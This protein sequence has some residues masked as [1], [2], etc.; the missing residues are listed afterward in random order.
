MIDAFVKAIEQ[1]MG[2]LNPYLLIGLLVM[3][4]FVLFTFFYGT[5]HWK[6]LTD[7]DKAIFIVSLGFIWTLALFP[8]SI[9][10]SMIL[11]TLINPTLP[12]FESS[13]NP[14]SIFA[15][16]ILV[17]IGL[18]WEQY[19]TLKVGIYTIRNRPKFVEI[20]LYLLSL[21]IVPILVFVMSMHFLDYKM[22]STA[23]ITTSMY[24]L[25]V[26]SVATFIFLQMSISNPLNKIRKIVSNK[27]GI[28]LI[29]LLLILV[30]S[31][32]ITALVL[33]PEFTKTHEE[34]KK[35]YFNRTTQYPIVGSG[36]TFKNYFVE[37]FAVKFRYLKWAPIVSNNIKN[38]ESCNTLPYD[39]SGC[40]NRGDHVVIKGT[41]SNIT[42]TIGG[43]SN[44][45]RGDGF[46][47]DINST[48]NQTKLFVKNPFNSTLSF[49]AKGY[50][51]DSLIF[52]NSHVGCKL[53]KILPEQF[54]E[55]DICK[56]EWRKYEEFINSMQFE[57]MDTSYNT[58]QNEI[59]IFQ[60]YILYI[61]K[62]EL[63]PYY[64]LSI[65]FWFNCT[66]P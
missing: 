54:C 58:Y 1:I 48:Q 61:G 44:E 11:N 62:L 16:V 27:A 28:I 46:I 41:E 4:Y 59:L 19:T 26:I 20:V 34:L 50:Y 38:V 42:V 22:Y 56:P 29:L 7:L 37:K 10:I 57:I 24:S 32:G 43:Y 55:K 65:E 8:Y 45:V 36:F 17:I 12:F 14:Y 3:G 52:L 25:F 15:G 63:P 66:N 35:I 18:L 49:D 51:R 9:A 23:S 53:D 13:I 33:K 31:A 39:K 64:N 6:R 47:F 60:N 30:A 40:I 5:V 2:P 21:L